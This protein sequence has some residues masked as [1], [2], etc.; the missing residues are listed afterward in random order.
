MRQGRFITTAV[1]ALAVMAIGPAYAAAA[2]SPLT[3]DDFAG[4]TPASTWAVEPAGVLRLK[5]AAM[6]ENFDGNGLP[7][8][9]IATPWSAGSG[10]GTVAGGTLTVD[11]AHV[12]DGNPTPTFGA[13]TLE[14]RANFGDAAYQHVGFGDTFGDGPW[15][16]FSTGGTSPVTT[17][18][19][20]ALAAAGGVEPAPIALTGVNPLTAHTFRIEW[21]A[22]EVKYYVDDA[23]TPVATQ[24]VAI[25]G[26]MRPVASDVT[27]DPVNL[28]VDWLTMGASPS[29]GTFIS[30]VLAADDPHTV[31][32]TLTSTGVATGVTFETRS[33]NSAAPDS[34]WSDWQAVANGGAIQSPG[35]RQNI[36]YRAT[37]TSAAASLDKVAIAYAI[38]STPPSAALD[39]VQA[40]GT[41]AKFTFS[42][43][44]LDNAGFEC[45]LDNGAFASCT[46]PKQLTGLAVG[47]HTFAV[48]AVDKA[49]NPSATV[50]K[51]FSIASSSSG[52][53]TQGSSGASGA[54]ADKTSPKVSVVAKSLRASKRGTVSFRVKCPA[55]EKSCKITLKLMNGKKVAAKKTVTVAGGKSATVTLQL[56]KAIRKQLRSHGSLK[57]TAV[58]TASDA[59][60]NK[61]TQRQSMTVRA[62]KA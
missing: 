28:K 21:S 48:R 45:S 38:D 3:D 59:A 9:L 61:R 19:A 13:Q 15:A 34:S 47:S 33:G 4:G 11:G 54:A 39:P 36:Q 23:A 30:R 18:Y 14:F 12:N 42:S 25:A 52:G 16:M 17:L 20:R 24:P 60:G 55:T 46:S 53:A 37:L 44:D 51:T 41:T 57:M 43:P 1:A 26:P 56:A 32:D 35:G 29:S 40:S 58:T 8:G 27:A 10:S 50:S 5:R 31:W 2:T 7:T 22:T 6:A 62:P 49:G